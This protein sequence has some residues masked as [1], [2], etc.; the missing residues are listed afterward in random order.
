MPRKRRT[1][2][3]DL[4]GP[5]AR[6]VAPAAALLAPIT[7][8]MFQE[9]GIGVSVFT[10]CGDRP[11]EWYPIHVELSVTVFEIER[12]VS[13]RRYAYNARC[14]ERVLRTGTTVLGAH[15][16]FRD[17]FVPVGDTEDVRRVL[18][19]G[20]FATAE[21]SAGEILGRWHAIARTRGRLSDPSFAE[22]VS[23]TLA[24]LMLEGRLLDAFQRL[25]ASFGGLLCG[26]GDPQTFASEAE[27]MRLELFEARSAERM[28]DAARGFVDEKRSRMLP[29]ASGELLQYFG[30]RRVPKHVVVGSLV[31]TEKDPDPLEVLLRCH[32]YQ[33]ACVAAA[34]RTGNMLCGRTGDSGVF[35]LV[36][37]CGSRTRAASKL[38][39]VAS[40]AAASARR[41]GMRLY[42]GA[43]VAIDAPLPAQYRAALAGAERAVEQRRAIAYDEP[44]SLPSRRALAQLRYGLA[45]GTEAR[46]DLLE[47]R[48]DA[49][50]Q[51]ATAHAGPHV[52]SLK[53]ALDGG[54]E[55][56][57]EPLLA[58][59]ALDEKSFDELTH[60]LDR[61]AQEAPNVSALVA[62]YRR[63]VVDIQN[64]AAHPLAARQDRS[65][66]R[67]VELM[68]E[69]LDERLTLAQV[70]RVAG[71]APGYF[72][73]LFKR[74]EGKSFQE[75]LLLL[76][77]ERACELLGMSQLTI[78]RVRQLSGFRARAYFN[79]TFQRARGTSPS[80]YRQRLVSKH[81]SDAGYDPRYPEGALAGR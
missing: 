3:P 56:L 31:A 30:V 18:V 46:P 9:L 71:F 59:G 4:H 35:F 54:L 67:A 44:Q 78:E 22:Y 64:A 55:R 29:V 11:V 8:W 50:V 24:T 62:A 61:A 74:S 32:A 25:V 10:R 49:Y 58:T 68:R 37:G 36:D 73:K 19:V 65:M 27:A 70:A 13:S 72:T 12:G 6:P 20:P 76:R 47:A 38:A 52:A 75:Y 77:I 63:C 66:R 21:P 23:A 53:T 57:T 14:F 40:R 45:R 1:T 69:R 79:R 42:A 39:E 17:L 28:W 15:A 7:A 51:A 34:R 33:K 41:F 81:R 48:F 2:Q 5:F 26:R 43:A 60:A 16:G 80:E